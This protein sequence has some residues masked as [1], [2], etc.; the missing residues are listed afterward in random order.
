MSGGRKQLTKKRSAM[1]RV[2]AGSP[3][4]SFLAIRSK[5][6]AIRTITSVVGADVLKNLAA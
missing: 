6:D 3:D 1:I 4:G 5:V 2:A